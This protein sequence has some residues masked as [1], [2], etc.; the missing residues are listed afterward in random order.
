MTFEQIAYELG[1]S[2]VRSFRRAFK[3]WTGDTPGA[4]R[5]AALGGQPLR[6]PEPSQAGAA[7]E[8]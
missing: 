7:N 8:D 5:S 3:R 2:N 4:A 6:R 1:F